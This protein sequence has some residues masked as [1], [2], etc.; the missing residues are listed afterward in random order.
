[1]PASRGRRHPL[2]RLVAL[3]IETMDDLLVLLP[4]DML[5]ELHPD[6]A[7][8]NRRQAPV[9]K[10]AE[11]RFLP[12]LHVFRCHG[13]SPPCRAPLP[14]ETG[15]RPCLLHGLHRRSGGIDGLHGREGVVERLSRDRTVVADLLKRPKETR[16]VYDA[17]LHGHGAL[18]VDVVLQRNTL[19]RVVDV[20][21][22][23][24]LTPQRGD[25]FQRA[26]ARVP[27]PAIEQ[28]PEGCPFRRRR[29]A[30]SFPAACG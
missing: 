27:V 30:R 6:T 26:A 15:G 12:P 24:L 7:L 5:P 1:M 22:D 8:Q 11:A 18:I 17:R 4:R 21:V 10:H 9:D 14:I 28:K 3:R 23:D 29:T 25:L 16:Q 20:H 2:R 19:R 13:Q